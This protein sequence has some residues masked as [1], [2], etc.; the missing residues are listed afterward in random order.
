MTI[1]AEK[2]TQKRGRPFG[3]D[4][5]KGKRRKKRKWRKQGGEGGALGV[6]GDKGSL[7]IY[8]SE[9]VLGVLNFANKVDFVKLNKETQTMT[10][11]KKIIV[12]FT[13]AIATKTGT[14]F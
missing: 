2:W 10:K 8:N 3:P 1:K 11:F 7:F 6:E 12:H 13:N 14:M 5:Q 9:R 4:Y